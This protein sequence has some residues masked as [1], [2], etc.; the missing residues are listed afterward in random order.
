M[1]R[2]TFLSLVFFKYLIFPVFITSSSLENLHR[3][4]SPSA[5]VRRGLAWE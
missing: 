5:S 2:R 1:S 3:T 4:N